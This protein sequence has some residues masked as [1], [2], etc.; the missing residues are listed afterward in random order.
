MD[1]KKASSDGQLASKVDTK[2]ATLGETNTSQQ[3]NNPITRKLNKI[4]ESRIEND[5][6]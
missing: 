2:N 3:Q 6:V 4:L 1:E 5:K